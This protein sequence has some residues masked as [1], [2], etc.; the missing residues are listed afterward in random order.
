MTSHRVIFNIKKQKFSAE[1]KNT[2]DVPHFLIWEIQIFFILKYMAGPVIL[3]IK[4]QNLSQEFKK[5]FLG[6]VFLKIRLF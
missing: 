5:D 1:S 2:Y 6:T 3:N 4:K